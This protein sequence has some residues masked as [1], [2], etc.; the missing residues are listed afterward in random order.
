M[1]RLTPEQIV[2]TL[3]IVLGGGFLLANLRLAFQLLRF[4]RLRSSALLVWS[5]RKPTHPRAQAGE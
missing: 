5:G 1:L 2:P 4:L 3:L